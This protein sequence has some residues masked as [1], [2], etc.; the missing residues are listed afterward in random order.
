M[1]NNYIVYVHK[2]KINNKLYIGI[3]RQ[4][5]VQR[6][7]VNGNKYRKCTHFYNAIQKYGWDNFEHISRN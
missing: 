3:T 2:N 4:S 6:S 7:G 5:L 1:N